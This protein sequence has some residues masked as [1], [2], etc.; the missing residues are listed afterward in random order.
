MNDILEIVG[1]KKKFGEMVAIDDLNFSVR[2]GEIMG[3]TGPNGSGKTTLFNLITG[4]LKPTEGKVVWQGED[5][6][7]LPTH[8]IASKGV[9]RTFQLIR[10]YKEMTV[11]KNITIACHLHVGKG[12]FEQFM[13]LPNMRKREKEIEDKALELMNFTGLMPHKDKLAGELS[14]GYQKALAISIAF[15]TNPKLLLLDE[16]VVTLSENRVEMI[17]E[18][19]KKLRD[20]GTTVV[21][22]EHNV[23]AILDYCDRIIVLGYGKK[24]A[25]G[26]GEEVRE[27]KEVVEAY[28]GE[29]Q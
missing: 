16:P 19:I 6:T 1:L 25:E 5:I 10:L 3:L 2:E 4:F 29:M 14:S 15:T 12:L 28:L 11:F 8:V 9:T 7:G 26:K 20:T 24:I 23:R 27:N 17:M 22:I 13:R 21:I 18:L